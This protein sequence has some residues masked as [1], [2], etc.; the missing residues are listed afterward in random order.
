MNAVNRQSLS[1]IVLKE[2]ILQPKDMPKAVM[3]GEH[4]LRYVLNRLLMRRRTG[5]REK[6]VGEA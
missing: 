2:Q 6:K 3:W 4:V 1:S 5:E